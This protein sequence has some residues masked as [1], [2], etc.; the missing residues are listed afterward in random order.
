[1]VTHAGQSPAVT[2]RHTEKKFSREIFFC[3]QNNKNKTPPAV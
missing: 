2:H 1:L 3:M